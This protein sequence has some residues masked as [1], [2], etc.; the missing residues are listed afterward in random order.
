M[1]ISVIIQGFKDRGFFDQSIKSALD[2][3]FDDYDITLSSDGN[4]ALQEY[5]DKYGIKFSLSSPSQF[6]DSVNHAIRGT[7][8][9]WIKLYDDDDLIKPDCL[10][11]IWDNR[12]K[13]DLLQGD[14]ILLKED[15]ITTYKGKEITINSFLPIVTNPVN[16]A[17]VAFSRNAFDAVGGF[18]P[19]YQYM[20]DYDFYLN[21]LKHDF[22]IGYVDKIMGIYRIHHNQS[23]KTQSHYKKIETQH[24]K[25]K[26]D[27]FI[28]H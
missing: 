9:E 27:N 13:G 7:C 4:P 12:D 1:K 3:N 10:Q 5:A 6:S 20:P 15:Q 11:N 8:G 16:W 21:L 14:A 18:D 22:K 25:E 2:Q 23:T 17:T 24:L 26:Y 28:K 19:M